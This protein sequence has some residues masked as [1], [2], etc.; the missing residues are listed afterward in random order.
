MS[1]KRFETGSRNVFQDIGVPNAEEHMIKAQLVYKIDTLLKERG[2]KN[3]AWR[4]PAIFR[5]TPAAFSGRA[6][7]GCFDRRKAAPWQKGCSRTAS[8]L[9]RTRSGIA[10]PAPRAYHS[11]RG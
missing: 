7:P 3:A 1:R 2:L 11:R 6:R 4:V 8:S 9:R 5:G 10:F